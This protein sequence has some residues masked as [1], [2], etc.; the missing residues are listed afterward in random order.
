MIDPTPVALPCSFDR[1]LKDNEIEVF[2]SLVFNLTLKFS[3]TVA[4]IDDTINAKVVKTL[5]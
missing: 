2:N 3:K 5:K 4:E 1:G